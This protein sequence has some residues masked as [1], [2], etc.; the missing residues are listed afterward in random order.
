MVEFSW[1][2]QGL[3]YY[4]EGTIYRKLPGST[5]WWKFEGGKVNRL[6]KSKKEVVELYIMNLCCPSSQPNN[7]IIM[8]LL[9]SWD[10][11]FY[12]NVFWG[13]TFAELLLCLRWQTAKQSIDV[14]PNQKPETN[15]NSTWPISC[16][17]I[18]QGISVWGLYLQIGFHKN[19]KS[20]PALTNKF[21][22]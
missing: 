18:A 6:S 9:V 22:R 2:Y 21:L 13:R 16:I 10:V 17:C 8:S 5:R 19:L 1:A 4:Y 20:L 14:R 7:T 3:P 11:N 15:S 12:A